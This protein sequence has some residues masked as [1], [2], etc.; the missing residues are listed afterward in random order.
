MDAYDE[1]CSKAINDINSMS[2]YS[3]RNGGM[4]RSIQLLE[5]AVKLANTG[6]LT[7]GALGA[8]ETMAKFNLKMV[9]QSIEGLKDDRLIRIL[10]NLA[11][12]YHNR[13][14][15]RGY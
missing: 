2:D 3:R 6:I 1:M 7:D 12:A 13:Y 15:F 8:I 11:I 5:K 10:Q 4:D 14:I 9:E